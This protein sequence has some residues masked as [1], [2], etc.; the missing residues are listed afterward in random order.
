MNVI[1][2]GPLQWRA[3]KNDTSGGFVHRPICRIA[4]INNVMV[5]FL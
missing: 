2:E 5:K 4:I 1:E 3:M